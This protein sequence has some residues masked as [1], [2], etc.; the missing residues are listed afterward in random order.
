MTQAT[1]KQLDFIN[2]LVTRNRQY[3]QQ[4][5]A[6]M[7]PAS[8]WINR[9]ANAIEANTAD[10]T[11]YEAA[12]VISWLNFSGNVYNPAVRRFAGEKAFALEV[13][14]DLCKAARLDK[15]EVIERLG[16]DNLVSFISYLDADK[17]L[18]P[19]TKTAVNLKRYDFAGLLETFISSLTVVGAA[20]TDDKPQTI[21]TELEIEVTFP[22]NMLWTEVSAD[23]YAADDTETWYADAVRNALFQAGYEARVNW[24]HVV[25]TRI[26]DAEGDT[27]GDPDYSVIRGIIDR[28]PVEYITPETD[29]I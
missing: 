17:P 18:V 14:A 22:F 29:E 23:D 2:D 25:T 6:T 10:L 8:D 28:V 11:S 7:Q 27:V 9:I 1:Q 4:S 3:R 5:D 16:E 21:E 13:L 24:S 15:L 26:T 19:S 12:E 20:E